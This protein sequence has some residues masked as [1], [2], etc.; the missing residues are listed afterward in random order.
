MDPNRWR[1]PMTTIVATAGLW[2]GAGHRL[3]GGMPKKRALRLSLPLK[4]AT[5][6]REGVHRR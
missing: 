3:V 4:Q 1:I 5:K 6:E 2:Q